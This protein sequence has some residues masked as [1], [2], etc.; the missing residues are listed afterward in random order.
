MTKKRFKIVNGPSE[1]GFLD[2]FR[3]RKNPQ[4][5]VPFSVIDD[6]KTIETEFC[7]HTITSYD[8]SQ[9]RLGGAGNDWFFIG[10]IEMIPSV[11]P[12]MHLRGKYSTKTKKG[13]VDVLS[14]EDADNIN[15]ILQGK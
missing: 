6:G 9:K 11:H 3:I 14:Q 7:I 13:W 1:D 10:Y 15:R 8:K 5:C 4:H 12:G 2:A